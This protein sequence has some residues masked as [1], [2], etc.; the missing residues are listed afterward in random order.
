MVYHK[1]APANHPIIQKEVDEVLMKGAIDSSTGGAGF[2]PTSLLFLSTLV[3]SNPCSTWSDLMAICSY[4]LLRCLL[5]GKHSNLFSRVIMLFL[6]MSRMPIYIFI[7]QHHHWF[8][9][10]ILQHKPYQWKVLPFQL[11]M[12]HRVFTSL[13][14]PILFPY[15]VVASCLVLGARCILPCK[16]SRL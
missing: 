4:L 9:C 7:V 5:S 13:T 6:L 1:A 15:P 8:L 10:F 12:V 2:T 3:A 16:N 14:K 11:A